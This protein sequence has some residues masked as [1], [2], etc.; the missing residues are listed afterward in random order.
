MVIG[1]EGRSSVWVSFNGHL[2][3]AAPEHVRPTTDEE[4]IAITM[5]DDILKRIQQQLG[6]AREVSFED[7]VD[8]IE[9]IPQNTYG[10]PER[11]DNGPIAPEEV[12]GDGC[13]VYKEVIGDTIKEV[14]RRGRSRSAARMS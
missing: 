10:V 4:N 11:K 13:Q 7:L 5:V 6:S 14:H 8:Q 9:E 3:K 1:K 12:V 2:H